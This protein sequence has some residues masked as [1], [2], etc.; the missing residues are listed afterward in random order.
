MRFVYKLRNYGSHKHKIIE[1]HNASTLCMFVDSL[2]KL[3]SFEILI[4]DP[5]A[6]TDL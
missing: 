4:K 2:E 6:N 1:K 3:I 5:N